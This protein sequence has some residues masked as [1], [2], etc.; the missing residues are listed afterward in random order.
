MD[1]NNPP[2]GL[3]APMPPAKQAIP[4]DE[5]TDGEM[6]ITEPVLGPAEHSRP[7]I[8]NP[9]SVTPPGIDT[10]TSLLA[11]ALNWKVE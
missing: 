5:P 3:V 2:R 7:S 6:L 4:G 1:F 8:P 11:E 9:M 10:G